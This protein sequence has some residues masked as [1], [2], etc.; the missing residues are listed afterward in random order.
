MPI[1]RVVHLIDPSSRDWIMDSLA[2]CCVTI[3]ACSII[4]AAGRCRCCKKNH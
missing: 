3:F 4:I 2:I 1:F